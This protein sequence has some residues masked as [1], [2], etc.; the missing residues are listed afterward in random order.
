MDAPLVG[1]L[2]R[3]LGLVTLNFAYAEAELE[4]LADLLADEPLQ[5]SGAQWSVC[6]KLAH[7]QSLIER[8]NAPELTG[9][10]STLS[11]GRVL[12]ERRNALVHGSILAGGRVRSSHRGVPKQR[13]TPEQLTELAKSIFTWKEHIHAPS[14]QLP[15]RC[16][17]LMRVRDR[18]LKALG[19]TSLE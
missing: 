15:P 6:R 12:L 7:A 11:K 8:L 13:V 14:I 1:D 2:I 3:P 10:A 18:H 4:L 17:D 19:P 5:E 9:L 16:S